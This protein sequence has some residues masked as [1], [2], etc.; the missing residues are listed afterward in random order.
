MAKKPLIKIKIIPKDYKKKLDR[1]FPVFRKAWEKEMKSFAESSKKALV[2]QIPLGR[3]K[4]H[5]RARSTKQSI[6]VKTSLRRTKMEGT[7]KIT[8]NQIVK[9]LDKGTRSSPGRY[10]PFLNRRVK[11]GFHPG[12][13]A[14]NIIQEARNVIENDT[15]TRIRNLKR[16]FKFS[17]RTAFR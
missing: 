2:D 1:I 7:I 4:D 13:R 6:V 12:I 10:L 11:T 17:I 16:E 5:R 14:L 9:F 15:K 3:R 8:G